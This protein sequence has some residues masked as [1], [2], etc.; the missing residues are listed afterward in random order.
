ML[1]N[2]FSPEWNNVIFTTILIYRTLFIYIETISFEAKLEC[3][4][5]RLY[6][7]R[8]IGR[9]SFIKRQ[10]RESE[11]TTYNFCK[12]IYKIYIYKR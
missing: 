12:Y 7:N 4:D 5:A 3:L 2:I 6:V 11:R 10:E 1:Q 8:R 9:L